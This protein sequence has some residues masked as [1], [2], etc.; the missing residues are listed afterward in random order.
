MVVIVV[1]V[2]VVET[3]VA[4]T[5]CVTIQIIQRTMTGHFGGSS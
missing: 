1:V 5:Y 2:V 4:A 3:V